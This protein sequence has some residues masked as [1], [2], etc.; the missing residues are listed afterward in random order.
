MLLPICSS[1]SGSMSHA[2]MNFHKQTGDQVPY[3]NNM[4][5]ALR[6]ASGN[7]GG[8]GT[9]SYAFLAFF[10]AKSAN[11]KPPTRLPKTYVV[12]ETESLP[13][14]PKHV[15]WINYTCTYII[16][17]ANSILEGVFFWVLSVVLCP[18]MHQIPYI[19]LLQRP[20]KRDILLGAQS[21]TFGAKERGFSLVPLR[22]AR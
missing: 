20:I 10:G 22:A 15:K 14:S 1:L 18:L 19:A 16:F 4:V 11:P 17:Q 12:G 6:V 7:G 21:A 3:L 9:G 5:R 8:R 13:K 2:S